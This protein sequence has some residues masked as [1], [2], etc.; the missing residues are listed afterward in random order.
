KRCSRAAGWWIGRAS[1]AVG[2]A[3]ARRTRAKRRAASFRNRNRQ[4]RAVVRFSGF[5]GGQRALRPRACFAG[6]PHRS[7]PITQ[8]KQHARGAGGSLADRLRS[9]L[10]VAE[11]ALSVILLAAA[12]LLVK[13]FVAL[14]NVSLG[15]RT[16]HVL[17]MSASVP[18]SDLQAAKQ[19][20]RFYRELLDRIRTLPG[21]QS[22]GATMAPPG[23]TRSNGGYFIDHLPQQLNVS[24]PQA[25]FSV[26]APN[27]FATLGIP[28]H[29]GRD[30][31]DADTYDAPFV[32]VINEALARAAFPGQD[33]IGH[34]IYCG[35]DSMN[36][37]RIIGV[38][39]DVRQEGPAQEPS[40]EI[41]MPY[42]QHP[43][44]AAAL[45]VVVRTSMEPS[46]LSTGLREQARKLS[47]DV[48]VKFTTIEASLSENVAAPRFRT[49][50][51]GIFAALAVCLSMAGV[52]GVMSYVV[53]QRVNEI[54]LRV[55]L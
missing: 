17:V 12:G 29:S 53:G 47:T 44:P 22:A 39:G 24:A 49:L 43:M 55:A 3:R 9:A 14:E 4:P 27:T 6:S 18:S 1:G 33:P 21:V 40:P 38:I 36:P 7:Q 35:L 26:A 45:S 10:V 15:F 11:I 30:F 37:M 41:Y 28:L 50:L 13:S 54:G 34:S 32:A 16:D 20:L 31:T 46:T 25:V 51:L 48:P 23:E 2:I 52:Y 19:G 42:E 8:A 5:V